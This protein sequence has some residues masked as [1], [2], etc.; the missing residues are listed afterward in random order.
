METLVRVQAG[1]MLR[2]LTL[3]K[4]SSRPGERKVMKATQ[5]KVYPRKLCCEQDYNGSC[6]FLETLENNPLSFPS[7]LSFH[8]R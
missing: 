6:N 1:P 8:L 7:A 2:P 5:S 3:S 4:P